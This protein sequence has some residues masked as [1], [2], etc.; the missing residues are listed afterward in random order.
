MNGED[1]Q[2]GVRSCGFR[3]REDERSRASFCTVL[4]DLENTVYEHLL[5]L[6]VVFAVANNPK[7]IA[8]SLNPHP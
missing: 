8:N 3:V 1:A 2:H 4:L 6:G 7:P 5:A